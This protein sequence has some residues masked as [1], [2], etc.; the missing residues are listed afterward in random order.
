MEKCFL[1]VKELRQALALLFFAQKDKNKQ[2]YVVQVVL[3]PYGTNMHINISQHCTCYAQFNNLP[4][5]LKLL[6]ET[7]K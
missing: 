1:P 6:H 2:S 7:F 4:K 3:A 5:L